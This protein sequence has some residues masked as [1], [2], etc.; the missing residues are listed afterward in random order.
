[1][2]KIISERKRVTASK[3]SLEFM[4]DPNGGLSFDLDENDKPIFNCPEAKENYEYAVAHPE[5]Y[6]YRYNE[7]VERSWTY[8]EPAKGKCHCGETVELVNEYRGACQCGR[9]GQWYNLFG[10]E[11]LPP[12]DWIT[13]IED[14]EE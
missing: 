6:P 1:M 12:E 11:L 13:P 9:C 3:K 14:W 2:L 10:E 7:V 8:T 4:I 5:V